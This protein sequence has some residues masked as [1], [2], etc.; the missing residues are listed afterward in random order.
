MFYASSTWSIYWDYTFG[1][2]PSYILLLDLINDYTLLFAL[3]FYALTVWQLRKMVRVR[4]Q[5]YAKSTLKFTAQIKHERLKNRA[6]A[7]W[8]VNICL[9][10]PYRFTH[11]FSL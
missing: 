4:W 3:F 1:G 6:V 10:F 2:P 9:R 11:E 5:K 7:V 8:V